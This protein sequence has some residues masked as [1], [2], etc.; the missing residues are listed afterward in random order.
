MSDVFISY[1]RKDKEFVKTLHVALNAN[2]CETW[3]DWQDIPLTAD[4][5]QEIEH[6]IEAADTFV[7]VLSADAI[8]SKV[9]KQEIDHA[10]R[11]NK[12]LI[13]IVR[14]NDFVAELVHPALQKHNWLFFQER[15]EFEVAFQQLLEAIAPDLDHVRTHTRLLV[16]AIEWDNKQRNDSFLLRG[17]DLVEAERWLDAA[18]NPAKLKE[19]PPTE[20]QKT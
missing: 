16:R 19:P 15:D 13:P 4:W 7:F 1:S 17:T 8:A 3:V 14:R 11:H 5:W 18:I 10:V 9:C 20:Q 2:R 12:R 6:G